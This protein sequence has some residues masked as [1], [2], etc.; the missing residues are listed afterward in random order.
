MGIAIGG[1]GF[2][3]A[4]VGG[5]IHAPK[6]AF[7]Q[8][9]ENAG[10]RKSL[11]KSA[12]SNVRSFAGFYLDTFKTPGYVVGASAA[13]GGY[14]LLFQAVMGISMCTTAAWLAP[15]LVPLAI[16]SCVALT[17]VALYSIIG[18]V[19]DQFRGVGEFYRNRF[20][21][22]APIDP[23][24]KNLIQ[25][26]VARPS[27]QKFIRRPFV[28]KF[29]NTGA[30]KA[31]IKG[32]SPKAKKVLLTVMSV[33]TSLFSLVAATS[34]LVSATSIIP[35]T[36]AAFWAGSSVWGLVQAARNVGL[37]KGV[38]ARITGKKETRLAVAA[39]VQSRPV[40]AM[41]PRSLFTRVA[42]SLTGIFKRNAG[43]RNTV[44]NV[45]PAT[46]RLRPLQPA[47]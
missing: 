18:G 20:Y 26:F 27:V 12:V 14:N 17:G 44:G 46:P 21:K 10:P 4:I 32:P 29:L 13:H 16:G 28:Q 34:V 2:G 15:A 41:A 5:I 19:D 30:V 7:A 23:S 45:S 24:Q 35:L 42:G 37:F 25:K 39:A 43:I 33:E 8:V 36:I 40:P 9:H 1:I 11:V 31:A 47:G 3:A 6:T 38:E 22:D